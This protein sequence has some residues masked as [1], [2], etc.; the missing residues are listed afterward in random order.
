MMEVDG[1]ALGGEPR[2]RQRRVQIG[3]RA[4][5]KANASEGI[6]CSKVGR[7]ERGDMEAKAFRR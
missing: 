7:G 2:Q 6:G 5:Y 4:I 3:K 1:T